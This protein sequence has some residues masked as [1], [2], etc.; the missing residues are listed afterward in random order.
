MIIGEKIYLRAL[1]PDDIDILFEWE[2]NIDNWRISN[3]VT[4]FSRNTLQ[5]Y[6]NSSHLDI[7]TTKQFRFIICEKST[8]NAIGTIDLF[9]F[10]P[11]NQRVGIGI[12]IDEKYRNLGYASES[13]SMLVN[14]C[15]NT[16]LLHQVYANIASDNIQSIK[17]FTENGFNLVG[18]KKEWLI[19]ANGWIDELLYQKINK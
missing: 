14:Y 10:E 19:S 7:Y 4:P 6:I 1:E 13:L 5:E 3:T 2:N 8:N 9:D 16:L 17:L 11:L 18:N 12:L 15:F